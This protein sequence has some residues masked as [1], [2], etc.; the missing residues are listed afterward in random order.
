MDP[1]LLLVKIVTLLFK[2]SQLGDA[3]P[4]S[5]VVAKDVIATI[6]FP[7]T[8]MDFGS[9]R[10]SMQALRA[11][12]LWMCENP[13]GYI[14]ERTALL[15]RIRVNVGDDEGLYFAFEQGIEEDSNP[16]ALKRQVLSERFELRRFLDQERI[17]TILK[18]A[19][20]KVMFGNHGL[21]YQALVQN[22]N[23]ELEPYATG[24]SEAKVEGMVE[25]VDVSDEDGMADL[26]SRAHAEM[27][28]EGVM[29]TG[30]Q[31]VNR[32]LGDVGGFRRGEFTVVG[33]LQH[34][35]KSGATLNFFKQAALYNRPYM[36][37]PTKKPLLL[38]ISTENALTENILWLYAN[39]KENETGVECDLSAINIEEAKQYVHRTLS[40]QG[41][42]IKMCRM[43]PSDTTYHSLFDYI[44]RLEAEGFEIHMIVC[45]YLN[46]FSK[47]GCS[48]GPA[49][50]STRDLFRRVRN[51]TSPRGIAFITP[52]QLSTEAKQLVRQGVENFV[53]EIANKGYYD[54]CR[55]IDQ[56]VDLEL[57]IHIVK[58]NGASYLTIQRGKHR[59]VKIT[60]EKDLFCVLPFSPVGGVRDD[61]LTRDST[62]K[63]VG[64]GELGSADEKPW[65]NNAAAA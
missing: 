16:E 29:R 5:A 55:T 50:F 26:M 19:S 37:D 39:L 47:K 48:E 23:T 25:E 65:W 53:Q 6:K 34:N 41:Y 28:D 36:R 14:Y 27:S 12:A 13:P 44:L 31:G 24:A 30:Y 33:A 58:L 61:I 7:E 62:R 1:K 63:H 15:Q 3:S 43:N 9:G 21:D 59:K 64:G 35:F 8:G 4:Q 17:K 51:F 10:E 60:P 42:Y 11:T 32:M 46:M 22:L 38:H 20:H 57:Y 56:E 49:G 54:S 18:S 2:E 52:H 45:D 40:A